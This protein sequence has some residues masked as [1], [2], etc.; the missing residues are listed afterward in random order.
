MILK[1]NCAVCPDPHVTLGVIRHAGGRGG[2]G[3]GGGGGGGGV[4]KT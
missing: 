3:G 2:R 4:R 1:G